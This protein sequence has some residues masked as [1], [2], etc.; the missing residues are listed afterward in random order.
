VLDVS[1]QHSFGVT[2]SEQQHPIAH[3]HDRE[4]VHPPQVR[5]VHVEESAGGVGPAGDHA[6][7]GLYEMAG[8]ER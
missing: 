2:L 6:G 8:P 5:R 3:I 7:D 1:I 4:H